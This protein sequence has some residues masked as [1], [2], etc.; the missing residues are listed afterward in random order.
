[1]ALVCIMAY[2]RSRTQSLSDSQRA[3]LYTPVSNPSPRKVTITL[4]TRL[5]AAQSIGLSTNDCTES[6]VFT[7]LGER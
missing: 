6:L 7:H 2:Y 4:E 3:K 1:V 5:G